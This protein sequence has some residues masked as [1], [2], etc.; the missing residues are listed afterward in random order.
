MF[1]RYITSNYH[2][3]ENQPCRTTRYET[4]AWTT[5][6]QYVPTSAICY[7]KS[8]NSIPQ[9]PFQSHQSLGQALGPHLAAA[10]G[11]RPYQ[12]TYR[13]SSSPP[14]PNGQN[15]QGPSNAHSPLNFSVPQPSDSPSMKRKQVDGMMGG[16]LP[17]K[18]RE[19]DEAGGGDVFDSDMTAQG[20]KHWS[21]E[22]KSK[23]FEWLM[24]PGQDDHWNA[25][26][27]TKNSCLREAS[28]RYSIAHSA[29]RALQCAI[30]VFESKKTYQALKGCYERNFN[31]FSQ[32]YAFESFHAQS[33]SGPIMALS[34]AD[35]L[36]EYERRLQTARKAGCNVG[37]ITARTVDHWHRIGWYDLF[38]RRLGPFFSTYCTLVYLTFLLDRWH[39]DPA[40]TRRATARHV[41]GG[42]STSAAEEEGDGD[43]DQ[44]PDY[45][46][47][48]GDPV[49]VANG[50]N[51]HSTDRSY[52]NSFMNPPNPKDTIPPL[53]F[54]PTSAPGPSH[55]PRS[56]DSTP[57]NVTIP[58]G[59]MTTYLQFLQ[60]QMQTSK[61][62]LEYMRR[63]EEREEKESN[64]RT[65]LE[66]LRL[67]R[68]A[69]EWEHN[70][71][72]ADVKQKADKAI[73][74]LANPIVEASVKQAA[75]DY[76]KR[77]FTAD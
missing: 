38:Y 62:K 71:Q 25:L 76:L 61:M 34:E 36:R 5:L 21:D 13:L 55:Q 51:G 47:T 53:P 42:A 54:S 16:H 10:V 57:I 75:G 27:A 18:R 26:R 30:E 15:P 1:I 65:E 23:L 66:R 22:E 7:T 41:T 49:G 31:L 17:K 68:D 9:T 69:A 32:I 64:Q 73:E 45:P 56:S 2:V 48:P 70:K 33:G 67:E 50:L 40:T 4:L 58:Q 20:A 52:T 29:Y 6:V 77:L 8:L 28:R 24:G 43:D 59:M 63:R 19:G 35:C 37:N 72:S 14:I 60:T 3:S 44:V 74:L 12:D 39:G 46:E 11:T